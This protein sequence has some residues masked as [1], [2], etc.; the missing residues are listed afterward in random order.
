MK[1]LIIT[2]LVLAYYDVNKETTIQCDASST[3]LGAT[4]LQEGKPVCFASRALFTNERNYAQ[5]EKSSWQFF[6][7]CE[8]FDQ[9]IYAKH[10]KVESDHKPLEDITSKPMVDVPKQ[11]QQI[12]MCLQRYDIQVTYKK[13]SERYLADAL[14][15]AYLEGTVTA[16]DW[17]SE[18]CLQVEEVNMVEDFPIDNPLL[19]GIRRATKKKVKSCN[20]SVS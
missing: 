13:E 3:G 20:A 1:R 15:R 2:T 5:I 11:L 6:L 10:T 18:H 16:K 17:Q 4:L 8:R 14:S 12:L 19:K 9:Y 7:G